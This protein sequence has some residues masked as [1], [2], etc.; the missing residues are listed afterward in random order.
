MDILY[1]Q[2]PIVW[3]KIAGSAFGSA[4]GVTYAS[5]PARVYEM[6]GVALGVAF[7]VHATRDDAEKE[8]SFANS[9]QETWAC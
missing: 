9:P 2:G 4:A 5:C 6:Q 7:V 8:V 1:R 3:R